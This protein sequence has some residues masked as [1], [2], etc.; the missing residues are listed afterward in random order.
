MI[1]PA[2]NVVAFTDGSLTQDQMD[3]GHMVFHMKPVSDLFAV[4][5][6]G[7]RYSL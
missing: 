3:R 2:T 1:A 5:V 6:D 7:E 4:S